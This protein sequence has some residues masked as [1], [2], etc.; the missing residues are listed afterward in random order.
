MRAFVRKMAPML[1]ADGWKQYRASGHQRGLLLVRRDGPG[2]FG[3]RYVVAAD[4]AAL[5]ASAETAGALADY[6]PESETL[7]WLAC[8]DRLLVV[9]ISLESNRATDGADVPLN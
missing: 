3:W 6:S 2:R 5:G 4:L 9:K 7:L 1:A 8:E